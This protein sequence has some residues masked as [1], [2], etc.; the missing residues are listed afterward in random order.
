MMNLCADFQTDAKRIINEVMMTSNANCQFNFEI[1]E[2]RTRSQYVAAYFHRVLNFLYVM[3]EI[4][5]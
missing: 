2:D 3:L 5:N 1:F 4:L